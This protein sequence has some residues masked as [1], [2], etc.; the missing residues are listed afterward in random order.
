M[1][2]TQTFESQFEGAVSVEHETFSKI[3]KKAW[4]RFRALGT[5]GPKSD[6]FQYVRL[7]GLYAMQL[8]EA[9][10]REVPRS[11]FQQ[12]ILPECAH[13]YLL[14]I[15]GTFR[16]D[17]SDT[18]H[19][20]QQ[21]VV[22]PFSKAYKTY[23][24]LLQNSSTKLLQGESNPFVL[25]NLACSQDGAFVYVPPKIALQAPLQIIHLITAP[26][27]WV[28][29]RLN[30][31]QGAQSELTLV[32]TI[33]SQTEEA[34]FSNGFFDLNLEEN[35]HTT[36]IQSALSEKVAAKGV[37]FDQLRAVLK[38]SSTLKTIQLT[39]SSL[40]IRRD[41]H[42]YLAG[43][44]AEVQLNGIALLDDVKESHTHV[45]VE[46]E[47]VYTRS[48]QLFKNVLN[49]TAHSSFEGKILVR[50]KAQ[51]TDAYQLNNNLVLSDAA[52]A[53][54][55]PNLEVFA[56]D[57][58][59]SHGATTGQLDPEELFYLRSRGI[60]EHDAKNALISGFCEQVT[61][62]IPLASLREKAAECIRRYLR[63]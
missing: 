16:K 58:K 41:S 48:M 2:Q 18:T 31:F 13:S 5:P 53:N 51:K 61:S 35:T 52:R 33:E 25:L 22:E 9:A 12:A 32:S 28:M 59:A 46:H 15:D 6:A 20:P 30:L 54:S 44:N 29:P 60:N 56:D 50:Q 24:T 36:L 55:K 45:V 43:E 14:F 10:K 42:I 40:Q 1:I 23:S 19:L 17:L 39:D 21:V 38:R 62:M 4:D 49:D 26:N 63:E 34:V 7:D 47:E 27:S 3:R 11:D 57:V 37:L 8:V